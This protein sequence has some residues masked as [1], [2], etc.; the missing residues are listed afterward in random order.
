M[1][2]RPHADPPAEGTGTVLATVRHPPGDGWRGRGVPLVLVHGFTQNA[3]CWGALLTDLNHR[4]PVV[5]VDLPG[6]GGS[7][8]IEA[9]L[10]RTADLL[11]ATTGDADYLGY[12]LGGRICLHLALAHPARVRRL[13]LIGATAGIADDR[14]RA[15]RR[16]ADDALAERLA[17]EDLD[18]FLDRWLAQ[19]LFATLPDDAAGRHARRANT[20][21]GLVASLRTAGTGTQQPLWERLGELAMPV[22]LV[23]GAL[24]TRFAATAT[25]MAEAIGGRAEVALVPGAGHACHLER[26]AD[27]ARLVDAFLR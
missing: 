21:A 19:P 7:S 17:A 15:E 14:L 25:A 5:A 11:A 9:D 18:T 2:P 26:P 4:R 12:S 3:G 1:P 8:A 27:V 10:W 16:Q 20:T 13:V 22:L 6:H 24:D 23:A